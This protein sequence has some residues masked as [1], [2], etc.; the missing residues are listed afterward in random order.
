MGDEEA[1]LVSDDSSPVGPSNNTSL[2]TSGTN[3]TRER[4][5]SS[6]SE[7]ARQFRAYVSRN[8]PKLGRFK[9][10]KVVEEMPA[11]RNGRCSTQPVRTSQRNWGSLLLEDPDLFSC[12]EDALR[13]TWMLAFPLPRTVTPLQQAY[14]RNRLDNRALHSFE[15]VAKCFQFADP[16]SIERV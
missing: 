16:R 14:F 15:A 6:A 5:C 7:R 1:S 9:K 2:P 10:K 4:S 11:P 13:Y 3:G 12:D 8:L